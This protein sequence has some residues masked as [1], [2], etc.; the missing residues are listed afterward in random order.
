MINHV[1]PSK[2]PNATRC[3]F[4]GFEVHEPNKPTTRAER[5]RWPNKINS[6]GEYRWLNKTGGNKWTKMK[7]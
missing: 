6:S 4:M 5:N 1:S 7:T 3:L 2:T